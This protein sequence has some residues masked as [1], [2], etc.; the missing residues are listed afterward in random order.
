MK[1]VFGEQAYRIP[2]S[3]TKSMIG[4]AFGAAG[5]IES[6]ACVRSIESGRIH[7]TINYE[8]PDP[9][10][11]LD[12]VPNVARDGEVSTVLKNSFGFGGQKRLPR[13]QAI[14]GLIQTAAESAVP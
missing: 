11:D 14:R 13:L 4:H 6:L 8:H 12:Y 2:V 5:P 3:S 9:E 7:P 1:K 10:C